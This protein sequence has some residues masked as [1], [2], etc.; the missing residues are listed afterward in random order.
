MDLGQEKGLL[1][2]SSSSLNRIHKNAAN[3]HKS[4]ELIFHS[5]RNIHFKNTQTMIYHE[6]VQSSSW[7]ATLHIWDICILE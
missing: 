6:I 2:L 7:W 3:M 1:L 5:A 4:D